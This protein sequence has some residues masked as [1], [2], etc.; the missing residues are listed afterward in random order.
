MLCFF[1]RTSSNLHPDTQHN[2]N[3]TVENRAQRCGLVFKAVTVL[4]QVHLRN[5]VRRQGLDD[6][7]VS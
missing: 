7:V 3:T 5:I 4:L 6:L 1:Q 2:S